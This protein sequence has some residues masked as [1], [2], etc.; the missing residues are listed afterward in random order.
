MLTDKQ[1]KFCL[2][3]V[4]GM[5]QADAYRDAYDAENMADDT[6]YAEASKLMDNHKVA[7]R[8][9]EL[10]DKAASSKIMSAIQRKEWLT[11][12]ING[13]DTTSDKMKAMDILN[14]MTGEYTTKVEA[15]VQMSYED[16]L[17]EMID[18]DED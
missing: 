16:K 13:T 4:N 1:E 14:K 5:T 10:R 2:N 18:E 11:N 12:V 6:I 9:Q 17:K 15:N 7:T 8:V 3:I